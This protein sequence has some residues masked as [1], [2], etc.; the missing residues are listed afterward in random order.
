ML[1]S[2]IKCKPLVPRRLK[3]LCIDINN[4]Y[5]KNPQH[6]LIKDIVE[7]RRDPQHRATDSLQRWLLHTNFTHPT[8]RHLLY[9]SAHQLVLSGEVEY[10][11]ELFADKLTPQTL[12]HDTSV[13]LAMN[14]GDVLLAAL[15]AIELKLKDI[16][17]SPDVIN[18]LLRVILVAIR[19]DELAVA[20]AYAIMRIIDVY[21]PPNDVLANNLCQKLAASKPTVFFA[22][23]LAM[24]YPTLS[25]RTL[26]ALIKANIESG[27]HTS[28]MRWIK[29]NTTNLSV[30]IALDFLRESPRYTD[31]IVDLCDA[32]ILKHPDMQLFL[33]EHYARTDQPGKYRRVVNTLEAPLPRGVLGALFRAL[34]KQN[35][36]KVA[37][38]CLQAIFAN[39]KLINARE[40]G[41]I[42]A[43]L[44]LQDHRVEAASVLEQYPEIGRSKWGWARLAEYMAD[45]PGSS[46]FHQATTVLRQLPDNDP[47]RVLFTEL[48]I[49]RF[50]RRDP[51]TAM[52]AYEA[53]VN[54]LDFPSKWQAGDVVFEFEKYG[55]SSSIV[56]AMSLPPATRRKVIDEIA[57]ISA[58]HDTSSNP[59]W[60]QWVRVQ[61]LLLGMITA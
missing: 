50:I 17:V 39:D 55:F 61:N 37:D 18:T 32:K 42:V 49:Q 31:F 34:L 5:Q 36:E 14:A 21:G 8:V 38:Q 11:R 10:V 33:L 35:D 6:N 41:A 44:L 29:T 59:G 52:A 60:R 30:D 22:N 3:R 2:Q 23:A 46:L 20:H 13:I 45:E 51:K 54:Y 56:R 40:V 25:D 24:R 4:L 28:A 53:I 7:C 57:E 1:L 26:Q 43:K 48:M 12:P 19:A 15:F 16:S 9:T 47:A 58:Q 27:D